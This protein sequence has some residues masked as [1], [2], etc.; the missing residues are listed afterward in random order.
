[1]LQKVTHRPELAEESYIQL[2]EIK[3]K[4]YGDASESLMITLKNL[5]G[6]QTMQDKYIEAQESL[7]RAVNVINNIVDQN[8]IKDEKIFKQHATEVIIILMSIQEKVCLKTG[9]NYDKLSWYERT[10]AKINGT[11]KSPQI[12]QFLMLKAKTMQGLAADASLVLNT[13]TRAVEMQ[14]ELEQDKPAKSVHLG[15]YLYFMGTVHLG[16]DNKD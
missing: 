9:I 10:L 16:M 1:M 4:Y 14:E 5:G 7:E 12:A 2:T 8:K 11:D 13:I 6:V 15:R 3:E